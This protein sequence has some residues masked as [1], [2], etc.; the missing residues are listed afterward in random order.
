MQHLLRVVVLLC[1][2]AAPVIGQDNIFNETNTTDIPTA[3]TTCKCLVGVCL[4]AVPGSSE[5]KQFS[6]ANVVLCC[7]WPLLL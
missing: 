6:L 5:T 1:L 4:S 2:L 3:N 7:L